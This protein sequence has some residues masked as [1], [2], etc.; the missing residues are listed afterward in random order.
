MLN[1][2]DLLS[3]LTLV[4]KDGLPSKYN[5]ISK[6]KSPI[7]QLNQIFIGSFIGSTIVF[8]SFNNFGGI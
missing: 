5:Q 7:L 8:H 6:S 1:L 3:N 2:L 4:E